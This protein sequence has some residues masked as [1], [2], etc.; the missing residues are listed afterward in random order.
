IYLDALP[1]SH[2]NIR[3]NTNSSAVGSVRFAYDGDARIQV[4]NVPPFALFGDNNGDYGR[5]AMLPGRHTLAATPFS[6]NSGGGLAGITLAIAFAV[7]QGPSVD[8][9]FE[10]GSALGHIGPNREAL[11][12][13]FV[14]TGDQPKTIVLRALGPSL[15][16]FGIATPLPDPSLEL[17]SS[18]GELLASNDN[19][20]DSQQALFSANGP[21]HAF[22]PF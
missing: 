14:I 22:R 8:D 12:N 20:R 17:R 16:R 11:I 21:Y 7:T 19:W 4:E 5:G 6:E 10:N 3:A 1:S 9:G 2:L 18:K 13:G 15:Q